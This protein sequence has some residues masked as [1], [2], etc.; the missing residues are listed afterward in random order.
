[1][2]ERIDRRINGNRLLIRL[3]VAIFAVVAA[4]GVFVWL[5][6]KAPHSQ[7]NQAVQAPSLLAQPI[8]LAEPLAMTLY[9]PADGMLATATTSVKRQPDLQ[10]QA[11][12]AMGAVFTDQRVLQAAV[13]RDLKIRELFL[14]AS[15]KVQRMK[16]SH[17]M[18]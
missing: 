18:L 16:W 1:M 10:A 2:S 7:Q 13:F 11:R 17:P 9:Y 8:P 3:L 15:G 5:R 12:E 6:L 4:A 14:D